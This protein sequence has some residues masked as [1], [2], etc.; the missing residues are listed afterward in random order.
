MIVFR[1]YNVHDIIDSCVA[2][3]SHILCNTSSI[4]NTYNSNHTLTK[5]T[6]T[7]LYC[8]EFPRE[9][10]RDLTFLR[11]NSNHQTAHIKII[12]TQFSGNNINT[13]IFVNLELTV[14]SSAFALIGQ[15]VRSNE[16]SKRIFSFRS[17]PSVCETNSK[18]K[19]STTTGSVQFSLVVA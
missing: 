13:Q 4:M 6:L 9:A 15:D 8:R 2:F 7:K 12:R 10:L 14:L 17:M 16:I 19:K 1:G 3:F 11:E 5:L 18:C